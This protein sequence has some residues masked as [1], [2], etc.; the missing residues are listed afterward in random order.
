MPSRR[1]DP[2]QE[3]ALWLEAAAPGAFVEEYRFH[4]TRRWKFDWAAPSLGL[5]V[6]YEGGVYRGGGGHSSVTGILRDIEKYNEAA[7]L[8]WR[9]IRVTASS[10]RDG[11]AYTWL[12]RALEERAA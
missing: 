1:P 5:A 12:E 11:T 10:V 2:K 6:E 3:I 8:G 9:V 4:P 7:L